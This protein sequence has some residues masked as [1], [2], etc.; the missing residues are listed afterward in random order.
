M[1]PPV[2]E[3]YHDR[4]R[5]L[6]SFTWHGTAF[7]EDGPLERYGL[8]PDIQRFLRNIGWE[9]VAAIRCPTYQTPCLEF[10]AT[11]NEFYQEGDPEPT[12]TFHLLGRQHRIPLSE[13]NIALGF[14]TAASVQTPEYMAKLEFQ[15]SAY[16]EVSFW[17]TATG[18]G[19]V[20]YDPRKSK[21]TN[22][23]SPA[24][25]VI[26]RWLALSINGRA[27]SE[28]TVSRSDLYLLWCMVDGNGHG[29]NA[30]LHFIRHCK[31]LGMKLAANSTGHIVFGSFISQL[32]VHYG[33]RPPASSIPMVPIGR[34]KL[35]SMKILQ[36]APNGEYVLAVPAEEAQEDDFEPAQSPPIPAEQ[37]AFDEEM[38]DPPATYGAADFQ[39]LTARLDR[40]ELQIQ[41]RF[42]RQEERF[43][44]FQAQSTTQHEAVMEM[45]RQMQG[46]MGPPPS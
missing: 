43:D 34:A 23:I 19:R 11:C 1:T 3:Q 7:L 9:R 30:G 13:F 21:S 45:L 46:R 33:Y 5:L 41:T 44:A 20:G 4:Y 37:P 36:K 32:A 39:S 15:Y 14:E 28:G 26:H 38:Q 27:H 17:R 8:L 22:F 25:R 24:V 2:P 16:N 42:D 6:S 40:M 12:V 29:M 10:L 31:E 35:I 18:G